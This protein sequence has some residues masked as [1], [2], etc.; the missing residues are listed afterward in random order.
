MALINGR[1]PSSMLAG[2][3]GTSRR[4]ALDLLAQTTAMRADFEKEFG[5][6]LYITDGY[7]TYEEQVFLKKQKGPFAATPGTSVHGWGRAL[8]LGS[9]VNNSFTSRE[10]L[11][12]RENGPRYGWRHPVWA[13][14]HN[15]SD[16]QDEPWHFEGVPVPRSSYRP[17]T[18][19]PG[20]DDMSAAE[21][22][23]I[24]AHIDKQL[25]P[26][27]YY[28]VR[29]P[30]KP[31][32]IVPVVTALTSIWDYSIKG[33]LRAAAAAA[34]AGDDVDEQAL[35]AAL[36]PLLPKAVSSLSDADLARVAKAVNDEH[37]RRAAS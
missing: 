28:Q 1:L 37:A 6:P 26:L 14:N 16:G 2:I 29:N 10:H 11:W 24:K 34:A 9:G 27:G 30:A 3:P 32:E 21:V 8:D 35:A 13:H 18:D 15:P 17:D 31:E 4:I 5:K 36:A 20:D 19:N 12:M 23:E 33:F 25:G 7:R 22:A